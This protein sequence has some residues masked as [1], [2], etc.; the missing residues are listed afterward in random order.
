M[1]SLQMPLELND[2]ALFQT[3]SYIDGQ[4]LGS[5]DGGT[6]GVD[7]P[8]NGQ[9]I[10]QVSNLGAKEAATAIAAADKAFKTWRARSAKDRANILRRWF[11]LIIANTEDLALLMTLEQGKPLAESR[12]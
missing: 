8:A 4:W 3:R 5:S 9:I 11:D 10:A 6:F 2:P 1:T 7:N 12:G